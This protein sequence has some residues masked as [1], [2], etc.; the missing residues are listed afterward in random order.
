MNPMQYKKFKIDHM[1]ALL[2]GEPSDSVYL[3]VH[4]K[5][6]NKEE[7]IPFAEI[8]C[9]KGYQVLSIDLP[10]ELYPWT[11]IP[12]LKEV[13]VYI[14]KHWNHFSIRANSIGAFF[15][16]LAFQT[17]KIQKCLFVSPVVDMKKLIEDMML[18]A[19][20]T[21]QELKEKKYISTSFG[22]TLSWEYYSYILKH[23][24]KQWDT[25]TFILYAEKDNLTDSN[26]ISTFVKKHSCRLTILKDGEHWFH[27]KEQLEFMK[28]WEE[29]NT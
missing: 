2:L 13:A 16:M 8:V 18:W 28:F 4:G 15:S 17:A 22:E 14:H 3:F 24:L 19:S 1:P 20:V 23:P 7:A 26:T 12:K 6:G 11:T 5:S 21:P 29:T 27:T 25:P 10:Q 9:K